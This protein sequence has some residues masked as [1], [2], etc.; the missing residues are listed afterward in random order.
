MDDGFARL[1]SDAAAWSAYR[2][3]AALWDA[4]SGDG[5]EDEAP[6]VGAEEAEG[7]IGIHAPTAPR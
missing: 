1:Q 7:T 6:Y 2:S 5:P 4:A 3:E